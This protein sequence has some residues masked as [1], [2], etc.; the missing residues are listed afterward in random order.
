MAVDF[1]SARTRH[2][3]LSANLLQWRSEYYAEN[4]STVTDAVYD[5]AFQE[6]LE[7]ERTFPELAGQDSPSQS[8]EEAPSSS[9]FQAI[10]HAERMYSLDNVF[11]EEELSSWLVKT[12]QNAQGS[13][14]LCELKVDGLA[15]SLQYRSGELFSAA[16]RGDGITGE[17]VTENVLEIPG[18]PRRIGV[19]NTTTAS[20]NEIPELVEIRGEIFFPLNEFETLNAE[21]VAAGEKPFANPRN[22]AA[23]S[24]RQKREGKKDAAVELMKARLGRLRLVVHGVGHLDPES[25]GVKSQS[26]LYRLLESWNFPTSK[27]YKSL[28]S[29][30]EVLGYVQT[31]LEQR[32]SLEHEID[33]V[34]VKVDDFSSQRELGATS[35]APRWAIAYKYPPEEVHTKLLDIKLGIGRTGRATPYAIME[36]VRVSGSVVRN[37]TLHNQEVVAAKGVLIGDTVVLR[38][39]GDVIPEIL[40]PVV[41]LRDGSER[42]WVMPTT[43][44]ECGGELAPA[45][46]GDVDLRCQNTR[47]CP[48]QVRGRVE[49]IGSRG[50]LD[51]EGLGEVTAAALVSPISGN[52]PLQDAEGVIS[53]AGLFSL[54]LDR[55]V[56]I[57]TQVL[58]AETGEPKTVPETGEPKIVTPFRKKADAKKGEEKLFEGDSIEDG[59]EP[60]ALALDL[61]AN[62]EKAKQQP[63][64]RFLVALNIRHVGPVAAR[65]LANN[66]GSLEKIRGATLTELSEIDG[67]G[68]VIAQ[69]IADW[70]EVD[71]HISIVESW[72][73]A[74]V[75]FTDPEFEAGEAKNQS[76]Q[77][78]DGQTVVITG[79]MENF[80]RESAEEAVIAA[81]GKPSSSV[82]AKTSFVVAGPGAGSKLTKAESLGVKVIDE[83][84]FI[85]LLKGAIL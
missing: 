11:S 21:T 25:I 62:L 6:L 67:V 59:F 28:S 34:V 14:F 82:S 43:C 83:A 32:G 16:T 78:L 19:A 64:W 42:K 68:Q 23:G 52:S 63:L 65:A 77:I 69:S 27:H 79:S 70:L 58:D 53:E 72:Q 66:F 33:G 84:A 29:V 54:T 13:K 60:S 71:W 73:A 22:A 3:E 74:G 85:E 30:N 4:A 81:G 12:S 35:R 47:S 15:I 5:Q 44:P 7:I 51:I 26:E 38:K 56:N 41:R 36:P 50:A 48:A 61:L 76:S 80:T 31:F 17:D 20:A 1:E 39:A 9:L 18:I 2:Q 49:H 10:V 40:G 57:E 55:L 37:A 45:K 46:V 8:F 24:L 75:H